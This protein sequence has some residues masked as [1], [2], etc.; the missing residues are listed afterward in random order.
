MAGVTPETVQRDARLWLNLEN[1]V[2]VS[3]FPEGGV[4]R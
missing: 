2:K 4:P 3:L 1:Y